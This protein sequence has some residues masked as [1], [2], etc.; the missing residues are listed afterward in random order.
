MGDI[1]I[2]G[3]LITTSSTH[4]RIVS[5]GVKDALRKQ[6]TGIVERK[7]QKLTILSWKTL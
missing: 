7:D 2:S 1:T 3:D 5:E 6:I 4:F